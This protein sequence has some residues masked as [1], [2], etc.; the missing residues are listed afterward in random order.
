MKKILFI[1]ILSLAA[2]FNLAAQTPSDVLAKV[3][4]LDITAVY[5]P[6]QVRDEYLSLPKTLAEL[7]GELFDSMVSE[8]LLDLEATSRKT[9][10]RE[11]AE[12]E[13]TR[14]T[15]EPTAEQ[16]QVIY[17]ANRRGFG[18]RSLEEVRPQIVNYLRARARDDVRRTFVDSLKPKYKYTAGKD[19]ASAAPADVVVTVGGR[20]VTRSEFEGR[21]AGQIFET[22]AHVYDDVLQAVEYT[23]FNAVISSEAK[24]LNIEAGDLIAREITDKM[25]NFT[26]EERAALEIGFKDRLFA[27][28][29]VEILVRAPKAPVLNISVDGEP[30]IG[31]ASAP[32]TVVMFSDF[33]CPSCAAAHPV[34]KSVIAEFAGKVRFV[35]KDFPLESIHPQALPAAVAASAAAKQ[36]KYFEYVDFLYKNQGSF[37]KDAFKSFAASVGLNMQRFEVDFTDSAATDE[38][39]ND[40]AEGESLGVDGTPSIFVNGVKLRRGL[41]AEI[42]RAAIKS[43]LEA[44]AAR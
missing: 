21:Y 36:G 4:G 11:L 39:R 9:S 24:S 12:T 7:R 10:V 43:A 19:L 14:K 6:T 32:V 30:T 33:E 17:D 44:P 28:Y 18:P 37:S 23:L 38:A 41:S 22:E 3:D 2:S 34:L 13:I 35:V 26:Q 15:A 1:F 25:R 8:I 31:P 29:K 20:A 16:I 5:L 40:Y 42:L 27:K